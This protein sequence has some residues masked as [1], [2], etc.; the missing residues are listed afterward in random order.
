VG[1]GGARIG[2]GD[3]AGTT[4]AWKC[5][6]LVAAIGG[7]TGGGRAQCKH[8]WPASRPSAPASQ[9]T[10]GEWLYESVG[11]DPPLSLYPIPSSAAECLSLNSGI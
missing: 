1:V 5:A 6:D 9:T 10:R 8:H 3:D 2:G 7:T 4:V 11:L